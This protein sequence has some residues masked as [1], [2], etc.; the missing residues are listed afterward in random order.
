MVSALHIITAALAAAFLMGLLKEQ[1]RGFAYGITLVT[2]AFMSLISAGWLWTFASSDTAAVEIFTAGTE[3]PFAIN[4]R[5]GLAEAALT[6]LINLTGL[7][8]ALALKDTL[9][10]L[11]RRAMAVWLVAV[12]ALSGIVLTRDLFNLFVF[13][14][15]TVIAT[16]GL[17]LLS[18]HSKNDGQALA[19]GFK[20]LVVSQFI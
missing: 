13:F 9:L 3:P 19:A 20:Y 6:L 14:E 15:L 4:L 18:E 16:A 10:G 7:L 1:Q 2:L 11:G 12:M 5:I 8:S 17:V